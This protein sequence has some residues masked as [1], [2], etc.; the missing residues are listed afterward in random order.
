MPHVETRIEIVKEIVEKIVPVVN[1]E[2]VIV[3]VPQIVEKLVTT[4]RVVELPP[5]EI[6]VIRE[7]LKI[8]KEYEVIE[9]EVPRIIYETRVEIREV[10]KYVEVPIIVPQ[11]KVETEIHQ[12][13]FV[14]TVNI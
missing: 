12:V 13:P 7:V 6:E 8:V 1:V 11:V 9:I 3:T 10:E 14:E 5:K 4:E 2:Q